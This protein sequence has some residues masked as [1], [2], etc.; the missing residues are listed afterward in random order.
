MLT[1]ESVPFTFIEAI[2]S[3]LVLHNSRVNGVSVSLVLVIP[4]D[5]PKTYWYKIDA[6]AAAAALYK[7]TNEYPGSTR[8]D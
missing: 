7:I 8:N 1:L 6:P 2:S 5:I 4:K 3:E